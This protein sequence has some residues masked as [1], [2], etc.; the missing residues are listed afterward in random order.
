MAKAGAEGVGR[1]G[2]CSWEGGGGL[3]QGPAPQIL[4]A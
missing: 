2:G 3:T 4:L 1:E